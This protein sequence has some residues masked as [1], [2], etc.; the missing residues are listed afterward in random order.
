[1]AALVFQKALP[2]SANAPQQGNP[3][4]IGTPNPYAT[5][6]NDTSIG[7]GALSPEGYAPEGNGDDGGGD[8]D[9]VDGGDDEE[10]EGG[11]IQRIQQTTTHILQFPFETLRESLTNTFLSM[12]VELFTG[13]KDKELKSTDAKVNPIME[14]GKAVDSALDWMFSGEDIIEETSKNAWL[15][16]LR[17]ALVLVPL[18]LILTIVTS[19][20]DGVTS[21]SGYANTREAILEWVIAIALMASSYWLITWAS[22]LT[23]SVAVAL[24]QGLASAAKHQF[25]SDGG[26]SFGQYLFTT[27]S[28]GW[29]LS[30]ASSPIITIFLIF[31]S[32]I[33]AVTLAGSIIMAALSREIVLVLLTATAPVI[34]V[35]GSLHPFRWLKGLWTKI[36]VTILL[37]PVINVLL[38]G[39]GAQMMASTFGN[40]SGVVRTIIGIML[41][42][43][44]MSVLITVNGMAGK[45][46]YGSVMEIAKQAGQATMG[47]VTMAASAVGVAIAGPAALG[48]G[49]SAGAATASGGV[50]AASGAA[51]V[52]SVAGSAGA[53]A[54]SGPGVASSA[55]SMNTLGRPSAGSA[56]SSAFGPSAQKDALT[57]TLGQ[58]LQSSGNP[59]LSAFGGGLKHGSAMNTRMKSSQS[60]GSGGVPS[61]GVPANVNS[62]ISSGIS[63]GQNTFFDENQNAPS[64]IQGIPLTTPPQ[65][66]D[67]PET[68]FKAGEMNGVP[69]AQMLNDAGWVSQ[70]QGDF[71]TAAAQ[72][73]SYTSSVAL[74]EGKP[75]N[76][77]FVAPSA[78]NSNIYNRVGSTVARY[79]GT[80][81][82]VYGRSVLSDPKVV[83]HTVKA[84]EFRAKE[85]GN[86]DVKTGLNGAI[87]ELDTYASRDTNGIATWVTQVGERMGTNASATTENQNA[88][89]VGGFSSF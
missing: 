49:G 33:S 75:V 73:T 24:A 17:V 69:R 80:Q 64:S 20:Q 87:R 30:V 60:G 89:I 56:A 65:A 27:I 63:Q 59:A 32:M 86:G 5:P 81:E 19:M 57:S 68:L 15:I 8:T 76:P 12:S 38:I 47:V 78:A 46:V 53:A 45:M 22:S 67:L 4:P 79:S 54:S 21:V 31:F 28:N 82:G 26:F 37:L 25:V 77:G 41:L 51:G 44:L 2:V 29:L 71:Q 10:E 74:G 13:D 48:L 36:L 7:G 85:L 50:S 16:M 39:L 23:Q 55:S 14:L 34:Y 83:A 3:P 72:Y 40:P 70:A 62:L 42:L 35:I 58:I 88:T 18:T 11:L 52:S 43:G 84:V 6:Q 66:A 9:P 1:M 61:F